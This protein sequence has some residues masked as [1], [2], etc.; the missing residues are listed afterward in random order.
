MY[1]LQNFRFKT[2]NFNS[3]SLASYFS[4]NDT[5]VKKEDAHTKFLK[6]VASLTP[7]QRLYFAIGYFVFACFGVYGTYKLEE[8]YPKPVREEQ[9]PIDLLFKDEQQEL[10]KAVD[11]VK[12]RNMKL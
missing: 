6:S 5:S 12:N 11:D 4:T 9:S 2:K 8:L 3:I 10:R 7:R 1:I